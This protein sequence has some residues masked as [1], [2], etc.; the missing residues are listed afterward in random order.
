M[1]LESGNYIKDLQPLNPPGTDPVSE[2]NDHLK[3]IKKVLKNSFPSDINEPMIPDLAGNNGMFLKV[4]DD[5]T[6]FEWVDPTPTGSAF[7]QSMIRP[8]FSMTDNTK[9]NISVGEWWIPGK[10]RYCKSVGANEVTFPSGTSADFQWYY[11][12]IDVDKITENSIPADVIAES[13][14]ISISSILFLVKLEVMQNGH[15]GILAYLLPLFKNS[16]LSISTF[17]PNTSET[18]FS[19]SPNALLT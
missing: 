11:V 18:Y 6:G 12:Y 19:K 9:L 5:G 13:I 14:S 10:S 16:I 3:L 1:S 7:E 8:I 2:G 4:K 15:S 17:S